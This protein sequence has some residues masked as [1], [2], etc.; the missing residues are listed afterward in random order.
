M[1]TR[2]YCQLSSEEIETESR[3]DSTQPTLLRSQVSNGGLTHLK[4][5]AL[6]VLLGT[7]N[8]LKLVK[9]LS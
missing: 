6:F 1:R 5:V 9:Y 3:R 7:R 4:A 8:I 2:Y